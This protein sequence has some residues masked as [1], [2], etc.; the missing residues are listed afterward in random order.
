MKNNKAR[1]PDDIAKESL[2]ALGD[3]GIHLLTNLY[4]KIL[5]NEK[6]PQKWK[7]SYLSFIIVEGVNQGDSQPTSLHNSNRC[8]STVYTTNSTVEYDI[9]ILA[10]SNDMKDKLMSWINIIEKHGLKAAFIDPAKH[11]IDS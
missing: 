8:I 5:G 11:L 4:N 10:E 1:G 7:Q 6:I 2:K 3:D 9:A